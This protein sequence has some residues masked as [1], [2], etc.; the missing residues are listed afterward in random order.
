MTTTNEIDEA[1]E[2]LEDA[3]EDARWERDLARDYL[4]AIEAAGGDGSAEELSE[5]RAYLAMCEA[6]VAVIKKR[7]LRSL[8]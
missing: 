1:L 2:A 4:E 5:A 3:L 7:A 6:D 8:N